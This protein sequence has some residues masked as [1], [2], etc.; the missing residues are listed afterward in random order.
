MSKD[1]TIISEMFDRNQKLIEKI[2][3]DTPVEEK[4]KTLK[5]MKRNFMI[6]LIEIYSQSL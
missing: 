5:A 1:K 6:A 2:E 4:R 3:Y